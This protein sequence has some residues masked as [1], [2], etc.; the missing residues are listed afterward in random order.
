MSSATSRG[1]PTR[2]ARRQSSSTTLTAPAKPRQI[3]DATG[4]NALTYDHAS[5]LVATTNF[6]GGLLGSLSLTNH[7]DALYGR[8]WL[9]IR[10]QASGVTYQTAYAYDTYGRLGS[11]SSGNY[12]AAYGYLANSDLPSRGQTIAWFVIS[13]GQT[14]AWFVIGLTC[15]CEPVQSQPCLANY[16]SSSLV[17]FIMS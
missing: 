7:S 9:G 8:D 6:A 11:V 3:V 13:R 12:S 10:D 17:P 1:S 5:R 16:E 2:T 4:T 14:I 15:G